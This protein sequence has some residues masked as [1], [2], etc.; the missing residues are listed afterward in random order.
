MTLRPDAFKRCLSN[1]IGNAQIH[2]KHVAVEA[3]RDKRF[4]TDQRRR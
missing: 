3:V 2:A 1:L 4:L